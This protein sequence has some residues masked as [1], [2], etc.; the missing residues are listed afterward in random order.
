MSHSLVL[1]SEPI[2]RMANNHKNADE[3]YVEIEAAT[4]LN[5]RVYIPTCVFAELFRGTHRQA[6][7]SLWA[8]MGDVAEL[9]DTDMKLADLIGGV[10]FSAGA[11]STDIV[12]AHCVA[13][14]VSKTGRGTVLTGDAN[15]MRRLAA[16]YLTVTVQGV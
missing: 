16:H 12:D 8:K 3:V 13:V 9:V 5:R 6:I 10:L 15:D 14:A 11:G 4:R 1:D 7:Y 2:S